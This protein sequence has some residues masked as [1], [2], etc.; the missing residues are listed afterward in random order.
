MARVT[1]SG[2]RRHPDLTGLR[3]PTGRCVNPNWPAF[4]IAT[5]VAE[6][7]ERGIRAVPRVWFAQRCAIAGR[8][9]QRAEAA[10]TRRASHLRERTCAPSARSSPLARPPGPKGLPSRKSFITRL[11][12]WSVITCAPQ[13]IPWG[14]RKQDRREG[15]EPDNSNCRRRWYRSVG[16]NYPPH[17]LRRSSC[18]NYPKV[19]IVADH[20]VPFGTEASACG[21]ATTG[22][23]PVSNPSS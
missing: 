10:S 14:K 4:L 19:L 1:A 9:D 18:D 20:A 7:R 23:A 12:C 3:F 16:V 6:S 8:S 2:T 5:E 15:P 22:I 11:T 21:G 13:A 17:Q